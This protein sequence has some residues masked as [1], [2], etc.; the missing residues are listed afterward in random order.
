MDALEQKI[1]SRVN[2][3]RHLCR[4]KVPGGDRPGRQIASENERWSL[5]FVNARSKDQSTM[6]ASLV[7]I[8]L[9]HE[10]LGGL[11]P[12]QA[13]DVLHYLSG[14]LDREVGEPMARATSR[15]ELEAVV[16]DRTAT[17][18]NGLA[19][20]GLVLA[21]EMGPLRV[22]ELFKRFAADLRGDLGAR[23]AKN[24][25]DAAQGKVLEAL[26]TFGRHLKAIVH[27]DSSELIPPFARFFATLIALSQHS[28]AAPEVLAQYC[29]DQANMISELAGRAKGSSE[30]RREAVPNAGDVAL[31]RAVMAEWVRRGQQGV[32][33]TAAP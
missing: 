29:R 21:S 32:D 7:G 3:C 24:L 25:P 30:G 17:I 8:V 16:D 23:M 10:T 20:V 14:L 4:Q 13:L 33:P 6:L 27:N 11:I 26:H 19:G 5:G 15:V 28:L 31:A 9:Q 12:V 22:S 18:V 1:D 2:I